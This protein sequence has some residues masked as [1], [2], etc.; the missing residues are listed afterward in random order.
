MMR[1]FRLLEE[2]SYHV[3]DAAPVRAQ[4]HRLRATVGQ[5]DFD[6]TE[7]YQLEE[8]ARR[9]DHAVNIAADQSIS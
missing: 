4:L 1:L 3:D 8:A 7:M 9:V 5:S 2:L 6:D